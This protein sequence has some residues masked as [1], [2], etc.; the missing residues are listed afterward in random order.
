MI[1]V[2]AA[3]VGCAA[4]PA[5]VAD[6]PP[7]DGLPA[8][9][10]AAETTSPEATGEASAEAT[11]E[12][13]A[14][15]EPT[16]T[17]EPSTTPE[18]IATTPEPATSAAV[19]PTGEVEA[20]DLERIAELGRM[21]ASSTAPGAAPV[22][23]GDLVKITVTDVPE[24]NLETRIG[25]DGTIQLPMIG[26]IEAA[27]K[28]E[29]ALSAEISK[30]LVDKRY[31]RNPRVSV[32]IAEPKSQQVAVTGAVSKP[33]MFALTRERSTIIDMLSEAGGLSKEAGEV[34][35][36]L[37]GA[38]DPSGAAGAVPD[39]RG[40]IQIDVNELFRGRNRS[41]LNLRVVS[42]DVIFVP[43]AGSF[44][45]NGWI[46]KPGTYPLTRRTAV[47]AAI[48]SAGGPLFPARLAA[49]EVLRE[50]ATSGDPP[51]LIH[52]NVKDVE[53]GKVPDVTLRAGDVVRVPAWPHLLPPWALYSVVKNLISISAGIP[54]F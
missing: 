39:M 4:R 5:P 18:P 13:A 41:L 21:R 3:S 43:D 34:V 32:F 36:F 23:P 47:L 16:A 20:T 12:P 44:T 28:S 17:A 29:A 2:F 40:A 38:S 45:I 51:T 42:G 52:V 11:P 49:V 53:A 15:P 6:S 24:L 48:A 27:G 31:V 46:D 14:T 25:T 19:P 9:A 1:L 8:D 7:D 30:Q 33:G 26:A 22:G 54:I 50:G 37:P 10:A 35:Q